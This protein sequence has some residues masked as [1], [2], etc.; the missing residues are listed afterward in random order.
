MPDEVI[1]SEGP[2]D[3]AALRARVGGEEYGAV[4]SFAGVVRRSEGGARLRAIDYEAYGPMARKGLAGLLDEAHERWSA[5]QAVLAH[6][7]GEVEVGEPS[8]VI[9]VATGHREEAFEICRWFIDE[10]KARVPIWKRDHLPL[11]EPP[12][13]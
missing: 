10:L 2:L 5:F 11:Q 3:E 7:T 13:P 6:R 9:V 1:L 4:V 8:V 12:R